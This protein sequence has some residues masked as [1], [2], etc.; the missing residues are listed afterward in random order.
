RVTGTLRVGGVPACLPSALCFAPALGLLFEQLLTVFDLGLLAAQRSFERAILQL[1]HSNVWDAK[2]LSD[3]DQVSALGRIRA[4]VRDVTGG[5]DKN[6][7]RAERR[8]D[9]VVLP[10]RFARLAARER[11]RLR[12]VGGD[13]L[14]STPASGALPAEGL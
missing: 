6:G 13:D 4:R 5:R 10:A 1:L 11:R 9:Q 7:R 14:A 12:I 3:E 2:D 8:A